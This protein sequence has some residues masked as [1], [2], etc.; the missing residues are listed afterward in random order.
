MSKTSFDHLKGL[1]WGTRKGKKPVQRIKISDDEPKLIAEDDIDTGIAY[2]QPTK[3]MFESDDDQLISDAGYDILTNEKF[4]A[5]GYLFLNDVFVM[6][7]L[8]GGK[9]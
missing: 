1:K 8:R 4:K 6:L 2:T 9:K 7:D 3:G 5:Q